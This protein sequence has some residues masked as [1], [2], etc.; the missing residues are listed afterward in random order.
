MSAK[1]NKPEKKEEPK[2]E[3]NKD[4]KNEDPLSAFEI[5]EEDMVGSACPNGHR[6]RRTRK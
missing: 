6:L 2:K 5:K 4:K 1:E 3:E